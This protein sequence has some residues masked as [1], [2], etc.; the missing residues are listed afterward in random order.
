MRS[1][2]GG[3]GAE[4]SSGE[5]VAGEQRF[6]L[7]STRWY[8]HQGGVR[9]GHAHQLGLHAVQAAAALEP[10]EE[11]SLLT[12]RGQAALAVEA[13]SAAGGEG[14]YHHL[15]RDQPLDLRSH[16][17]HLT[18]ELVTHDGPAVE[19]RFATVVH[20]QVRTAHRRQAHA[21][22]GVLGP[23]QARLGHVEHAHRV[24]GVEGDGFHGWGGSGGGCPGVHGSTGGLA[25][26]PLVQTRR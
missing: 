18:Q 15:A 19:P 7:A 8:A 16:L 14:R 5:H 13:D 9:Q 20:V 1:G 4:E 2:A 17:E 24:H 11:L 6:L 10:A 21:H 23:L 25:A 26:H 22:Q 12:A 3:L